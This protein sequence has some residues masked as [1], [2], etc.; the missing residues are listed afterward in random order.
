MRRRDPLTTR[1]MVER[2]SIDGGFGR[3]VLWLVIEDCFEVGEGLLQGCCQVCILSL[4]LFYLG[5]FVFGGGIFLC[6]DGGFQSAE[7]LVEVVPAV[8]CG[9]CFGVYCGGS[10]G[11]GHGVGRECGEECK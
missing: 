10:G 5:G 1:V 8:C 11:F 7:C 4:Q 6:E 9:V 3:S 2:G